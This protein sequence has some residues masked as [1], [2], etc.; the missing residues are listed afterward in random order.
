VKTQAIGVDEGL[1]VTRVYPD[2]CLQTM[3]T[4]HIYVPTVKHRQM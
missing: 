2:G 3:Y 4:V 1:S